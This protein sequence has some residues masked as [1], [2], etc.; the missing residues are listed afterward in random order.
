MAKFTFAADYGRL[1]YHSRFTNLGSLFLSL[2]NFPWFKVKKKKCK[3]QSPFIINPYSLPRPKQLYLLPLIQFPS[4]WNLTAT[5]QPQVLAAPF[6][7][8][9]FIFHTLWHKQLRLLSARP[10]APINMHQ[11]TFIETDGFR[12]CP[13]VK[14]KKELEKGVATWLITAHLV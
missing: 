3:V 11:V 2:K 13:L 5:A 7:Q 6:C 12:V 10:Q 14:A 8:G 4:T 9:I 1:V